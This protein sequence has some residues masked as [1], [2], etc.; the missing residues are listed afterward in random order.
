MPTNFENVFGNAVIG[1]RQALGPLNASRLLNITVRVLQAVAAQHRAARNIIEVARQLVPQNGPALTGAELEEFITRMSAAPDAAA[2]GTQSDFVA[3]L[4]TAPSPIT[5]AQILALVNTLTAGGGGALRPAHICRLVHNLRAG[6][7]GL[8]PDRVRLLVNRLC[9]APAAAVSPAEFREIVEALHPNA[10]FN[11]TRVRTS[12]LALASGGHAITP[13]DLLALVRA[14]RDTANNG[15]AALNGTQIGTL[16]DSL[17]GLSG[18]EIAATLNQLVTPG[19]GG[20]I[21]PV[22]TEALV[23]RLRTSLSAAQVHAVVT[24]TATLQGHGTEEVRPAFLRQIAAENHADGT[25]FPA[26]LVAA[27]AAS[28]TAR[29]AIVLRALRAYA[30]PVDRVCAL[31]AIFPDVPGADTRHTKVVRYL[32]DGQTAAAGYW[33]TA[34]TDHLDR[35]VY[36]QHAPFGGN[37]PYD[38]AG[39]G[40]ADED[41]R[42]LG[43]DYRIRLREHRLNYFCN[44]H[45]YR[46]LDFP[47]RINVNATI[48][49]WPRAQNRNGVLQDYTTLAGAQAAWIEDLAEQAYGAYARYAVGHI[50]ALELGVGTDGQQNNRYRV[51]VTHFSPVA[52]HRITHAALVALYHIVH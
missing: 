27:I 12:V 24:T 26:L 36:A 32:R 11:G 22:Q 6:G 2:L 19:G 18:T 16:I 51:A 17:A 42:D 29:M 9:G 13:Q 10:A 46:H 39:M 8:T 4:L 34:V 48:E 20:P 49:L 43:N 41:V 14:L 25:T 21:T 15:A 30:Y 40:G 50:G 38:D 47:G 52:Q 35:F 7:T 45:T 33:K 3:G 23:A 5:P 1:A 37:T 28:T 31:L 44:A